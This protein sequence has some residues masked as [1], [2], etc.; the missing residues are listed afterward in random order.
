MECIIVASS[1]HERDAVD[2][3]ELQSVERR[4]AEYMSSG[5]CDLIVVNFDVYVN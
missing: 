2:Y 5:K 3:S 4:Q 1:W